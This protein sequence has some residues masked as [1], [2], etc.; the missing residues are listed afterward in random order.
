MCLILT[1]ERRLAKE[2]GQTNFT[3]IFR[4]TNLVRSHSQRRFTLL[5]S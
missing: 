4:G 2:A 3:E 5:E 1:E